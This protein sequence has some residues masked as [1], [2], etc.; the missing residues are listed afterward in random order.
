MT[1]RPRTVLFFEAFL[2]LLPS[3]CFSQIQINPRDI[4]PGTIDETEFGY[5]NGLRANIQQQIDSF[6]VISNAITNIVWLPGSDFTFSRTNNV[7][8]ETYPT[9]I[10]FFIN[11]ANYITAASTFMGATNDYVWTT[12]RVW[13]VAIAN[14]MDAHIND[15]IDNATAG[16]TLMLPSGSF[17]VDSA[18][19][20]NKSLTI[21]GQGLDSTIINQTGDGQNTFLIGVSNVRIMDLTV[22]TITAVAGTAIAV[23]APGATSGHIIE[24]VKVDY[25]SSGIL[26]GF[27]GNDSSGVIKNSIFNVISSSHSAWGFFN[28]PIMG[29]GHTWNLYNSVFTASGGAG[30]GIHA[31]DTGGLA[32]TV[33]AFACILAGSDAGARVKGSG[34]TVV[35][36]RCSA[37]GG[38]GD[39]RGDS[40]G[41]MILRGTVLVN[42]TTKGSSTISRD[43]TIWATSARFD[44]D[45][46]WLGTNRISVVDNRLLIV[47]GIDTY[48]TNVPVYFTDLAAYD[49]TVWNL[50]IQDPTNGVAYY[51]PNPV[52]ANVELI[53]VFVKSH[54]M[55]GN[56]DV[57]AQNRTSLWYTYA[58]V[59][60]DIV[61]DANGTAQT[62]FTGDQ[63]WTNQHRMGFLA[64][65][66]SSFAA[67]NLL[68]VDFKI[69]R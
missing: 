26:Y 55:T 67:T 50:T 2:F 5:L 37:N 44:A 6:G 58:T 17:T 28:Q 45:S 47:A 43:G 33:N 42:N 13:W 39:V 34:S 54:G 46:I 18:I 51:L 7:G 52:D 14:D 10:G 8:Y 16:D 27:K 65:D 19:V 1:F 32:N 68:S 15:T 62:S 57:I 53:E 24:N 63:T 11:D 12:G 66:L 21:R 49:T 69:T 30:S 59:Q 23:S 48:A 25:N 38:D 56:V 31:E 40:S 9:N 64:S 20:I 36:E 4:K 41:T 22:K 35:L 61:A 60:A 29:S 3:F